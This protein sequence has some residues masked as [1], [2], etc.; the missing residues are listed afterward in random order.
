MN[1]MLVPVNLETRMALLEQAR[2]AARRA[3]APYSEF[4]VGAAILTVDGSM[5]TGC[6]VENASYGLTIC[7]ER[8]AASAAINAGQRAFRAVAVSAPKKIGTT[9]CGA[10]RQV[11]SE[12]RPE[13]G[14]MAVILDD[15]HSGQLLWLSDLLPQA[16][17]RTEPGHAEDNLRFDSVIGGD[18]DA[19]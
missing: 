10:C 19:R 13:A 12:F 18:E 17:H 1:E 15:E 3:Y 5:Y 11:L 8:A 2:H 6:N 7:A 4:P 16:F 9:P 14:D